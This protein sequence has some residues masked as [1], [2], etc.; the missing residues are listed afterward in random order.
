[1]DKVMTWQ[2]DA[3]SCCS[4]NS[5]D[6]VNGGVLVNYVLSHLIFLNIR[7]QAKPSFSVLMFTLLAV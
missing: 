6:S 2:Q 3:R 1:M 4:I 7:S 5:N